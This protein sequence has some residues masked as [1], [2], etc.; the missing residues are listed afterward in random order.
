MTNIPIFTALCQ[1]SDAVLPTCTRDGLNSLKPCGWQTNDNGLAIAAYGP[2]I[3]K[4]KAGNGTDVTI[5][6]ETDYPFR[7]SV[8]LT[9]NPSKA[10]R[11]PIYLRKPA[12]ADSLTVKVK[13]KTLVF[14]GDKPVRLNERWRNGDQ[15][16]I[17]IPMGLRIERRY[18][19]SATIMRGPLLLSLKIDK[20]YRSI[21]ANYDNYSYK[22]SIDWEIDPKS[23]W[24]YGLL[25]DP[26]NIG[27]G[28]N[29]TEN[30]VTDYPFADNGDMVWSA[31]T[32][33]ICDIQRGCT[34]YCY[35][36]RNTY[37]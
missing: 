26:V 27:R 19:N 4:A 10:A 22:G 16:T 33:K 34:S 14:K 28:L 17:E 36:Q 1:I 37:P 32:G 8:K 15:V 31:E 20:E 23:P 13:D 24:N 25:L 11:F 6:E 7:G 21:K 9:I 29:V 5:T 35:S 2:S 18:N 30:K 3:V 12:W